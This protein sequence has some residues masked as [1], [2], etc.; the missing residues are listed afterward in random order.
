MFF[1]VATKIL[2]LLINN[3]QFHNLVKQWDDQEI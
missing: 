3:I 2:S 1:L